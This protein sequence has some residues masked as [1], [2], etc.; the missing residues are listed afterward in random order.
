[1]NDK[2]D[3]QETLKKEF[4][5]PGER[6]TALL[7]IVL[8]ILGYY[9]AMGMTSETFYS[10]SVVPKLTSTVVAVCAAAALF[11]TRTKD[12]NPLDWRRTLKYFFPKDVL[13]ILVFLVA[14]SFMLP[15]AGFNI[16][17]AVFLFAAIAYLQHWKNLIRAA[18]ISVITVAVL[19]LVFR[20]MFL[21]ILP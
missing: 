20:Y 2:A 4:C 13:V 21:V 1:M 16:A 17:S 7:I 5:T 15:L 14:Y 19:F 3:I 6:L 8:G 12:K 10:P 9:F 11:R 18:V